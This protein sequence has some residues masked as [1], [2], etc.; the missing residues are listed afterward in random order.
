[1]CP[2]S[3]VSR[4]VSPNSPVLNFV[5][6]LY[7]SHFVIEYCIRGIRTKDSGQCY[8][9]FAMSLLFQTC[10]HSPIAIQAEISFEKTSYSV[11]EDLTDSKNLALVVCATAEEVTQAVTVTISTANGTAVGEPL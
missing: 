9:S 8:L 4:D 10:D 3:S 7:S 2:Q 11:R 6:S 1:M 5:Y